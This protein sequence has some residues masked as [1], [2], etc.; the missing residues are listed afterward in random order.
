VY[1]A[2]LKSN[3]D[4]LVAVKKAPREY[5]EFDETRDRFKEEYLHETEILQH[6]DHPN[7]IRFVGGSFEEAFF[8]LECE[9]PWACK[10][11]C[12]TLTG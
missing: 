1:L 9:S 12:L 4:E 5:L 2:R 11:F 3:P 6:L 10:D 8:C 7:V